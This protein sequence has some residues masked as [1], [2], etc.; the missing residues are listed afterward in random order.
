MQWRHYFLSMV[1]KYMLKYTAMRRGSNRL[2][3]L[4]SEYRLQVLQ[5]LRT[6][7]MSLTT[8]SPATWRRGNTDH[9]E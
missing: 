1:I 7:L 8:G 9:R 6:A 3:L 4:D 5:Q 2:A